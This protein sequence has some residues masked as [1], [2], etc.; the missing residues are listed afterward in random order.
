MATESQAELQL[1]ASEL[2]N[3][4]KSLLQQELQD[5]HESDA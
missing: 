1:K 3:L 5:D 4:Q 2:S